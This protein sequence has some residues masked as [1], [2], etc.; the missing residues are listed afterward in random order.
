MN[1]TANER[2]RV[3]DARR[4]HD[5]NNGSVEQSVWWKTVC[6]N[7]DPERDQARLKIVW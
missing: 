5:G 2:E 3:P 1:S 4:W 7:A 6:K